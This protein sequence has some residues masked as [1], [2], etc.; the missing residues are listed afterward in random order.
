VV[1]TGIV[2]AATVTLGFVGYLRVFIELPETPVIIIS[3]LIMG[4]LAAWG[5]GQSVVAASV[6]TALEISGLLLVIALAGHHLSEIPEHGWNLLPPFS[7]SAWGLIWLG[8]YLAFF[9]FIGFEDMVNLAEEVKEPHRTL[10]KAIVVCLLV[11]TA[12]YV[13]I[14]LIAI[15]ALP[16]EQLQ[17]E[18]A[19]LAAILAERGPW[20][21]S[22]ISLISMVA[23]INGA[24]IQIIM[25]SRVLYGMAKTGMAPR[26]FG[27]VSRHTQ[28]PILATV[29]ATLVITLL[30]VGFPLVSLAKATSGVTLFVFALVNASLWRLKTRPGDASSGDHVTYPLWV[31]V[32]GC[33][34]SSIALLTS[35]LHGLGE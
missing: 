15:L 34:L 22:L 19:P 4:G 31:P 21:R 11:S 8:A 33:L 14:A 29:A 30:A 26:P 6:V 20:A 2:S 1:I 18:A 10:P 35:V 9:A 16:P 24:L 32:T 5:I 12:F 27:A 13:L 17:G 28:T 25:A 7:L 23:V 3:L